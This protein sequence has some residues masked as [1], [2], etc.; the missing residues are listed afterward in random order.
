MKQLIL[1]WSFCVFICCKSG[2]ATPESYFMP[3]DTA[4][5]MA[6]EDAFFVSGAGTVVTGTIESGTAVPG[7]KVE[8]R[9]K[10]DK[11]HTAT[12]GFISMYTKQVGSAKKGDA[13]GLNIK[14]VNND[15]I[16]RGMVVVAPNTIK[17]YSQVEI[18]ID[19]LSRENALK[20]ALQDNQSVQIINRTETVSATVLSTSGTKAGQTDKV[21][22]RLAYAIAL[23]HN[24]KLSIKYMGKIAGTGIFIKPK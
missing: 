21:V 18:S 9:G 22:L 3:E 4:F 13:I 14:G 1:A 10:G 20:A 2:Y 7:M 5:L 19:P 17:T 11:V 8:I 23:K 16:K 6:V 24:D 12:V 15:E